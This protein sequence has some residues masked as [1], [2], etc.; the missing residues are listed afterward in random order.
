MDGKFK[1]QHNDIVHDVAYD[2]YGRRMATCSA[3]QFIK[4]WE[5]GEDGSWKCVASWKAHSG[6]VNRIAWAHPEFG[7]VIASCS[8]DRTINIWEEVLRPSHSGEG[9][10]L[11]WLRRA[12]LM[13]SRDKVNDVKFA[14]HHVGLKFAACS[15]D[16]TVRIY[17]A[18][19][20]L[21]LTL[22]TPAGE[23]E[24]SKGGATSCSWCSSRFDP[25]ML[26]VGTVD[27]AI[28]IWQYNE[29]QRKWV[30]ICTLS[31]HADGIHDV[32]WA[33]LMGRHS[34]YIASGSK[35]HSVRIWRVTLEDDSTA[36]AETIFSSD[37]HGAE[38][39]RV[40]WNVT[41]T[42]L[43]SSGDD[44]KVR[45]WRSDLNGEWTCALTIQDTEESSST[46]TPH[47]K[48]AASS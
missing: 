43:S 38:V 23:F 22:W 44:G 8:F 30:G 19:D 42:A 48:A 41:G 25:V 40:E 39:W 34:H 28:K 24:A 47:S 17:E 7:Q 2:Y 10:S 3:D 18:P 27:P 21:N 46:S 15:S 31:G 12:T 13:D 4:I 35:D 36:E 20:P 33:P 11:T 9:S 1:T 16:G 32:S 37:D 14:P 26:V 45:V 5:L 29:S 6:P